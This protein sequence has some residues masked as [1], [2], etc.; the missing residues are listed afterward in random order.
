[1][2]CSDMLCCVNRIVCEEGYKTTYGSKGER[3]IDLGEGRATDI[4]G[5]PHDRL[6]SGAFDGPQF[7]DYGGKR[8]SP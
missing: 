7:G 3:L 5:C 8:F 4:R 2:V 6:F 1:M